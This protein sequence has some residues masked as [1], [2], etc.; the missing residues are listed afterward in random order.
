MQIS[1]SFLLLIQAAVPR[2][3]QVEGCEQPLRRRHLAQVSPESGGREGLLAGGVEDLLQGV[4]LKPHQRPVVLVH[5]NYDR[6]PVELACQKLLKGVERENRTSCCGILYWPGLR[7][8]F[9]VDESLCIK[10]LQALELI[11]SV[12]TSQLFNNFGAFF[13]P[14]SGGQSVHS[15][16]V[17]SR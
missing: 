1:Y 5:S 8:K 14:L 11:V 13:S 2:S 6:H 9:W 7:I 3:A 10:Q 4:L 12:S 16:I 15:K 17:R